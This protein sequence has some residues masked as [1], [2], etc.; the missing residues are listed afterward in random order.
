MKNITVAIVLFLSIISCDPQEDRMFIVNNKK[1]DIVVRMDFNHNDNIIDDVGGI[2][3]IKPMSKDNVVKL[4]SWESDFEDIKPDS[5]L[6]VIVMDK[7]VE[8]KRILDSLYVLGE[9]E[10]RSYSYRDLEYQDW[11]ITYPDDGFI[12]GYKV[13]K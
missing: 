10:Y 11:I 9:Y 7:K 13:E 8:E 5:L 2:K 1:T 6:L 12:K 3:Y 4:F